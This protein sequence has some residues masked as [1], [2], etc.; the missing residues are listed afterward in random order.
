[1]LEERRRKRIK[2]RKEKNGKVESSKRRLASENTKKKIKREAE[3]K[4]KF[5]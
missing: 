4:K 3:K 5:P 1:M 2:G